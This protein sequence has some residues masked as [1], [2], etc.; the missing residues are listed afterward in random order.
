ML[1]SQLERKLTSVTDGTRPVCVRCRNHSQIQEVCTWPPAREHGRRE[2]KAQVRFR[3]RNSVSHAF[4]STGA[5]DDADEL[6]SLPS[7]VNILSESHGWCLP[8]EVTSISP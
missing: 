5:A 3:A 2:S 4:S 7:P 6:A 1:L 8:E